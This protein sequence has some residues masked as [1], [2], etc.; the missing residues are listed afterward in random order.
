MDASSGSATSSP[1]ERL[2]GEH[3]ET[4]SALAERARR[5]IPGG[6]HTYA[7]GD[8]QFPVLA[9]PFIARGN[10]CRTWDLDGNQYIE[11]AMG[12][13]AVT[14][15]H[16]YAPV[17]EAARQQ[18][19]FGANFNRPAPIEVEC[20]EAFLSLLP[21]ADMV[22]FTKDGSTALDAAVRLSR[23]HTKRD[24]VAICGDHPFFSTS[25]WFI[26]TTGMP[27]G[28]PEWIRSRTIS[29]SYNDLPSVERM[30]AAYPQQIACV[31]LEAAR[32]VEPA[33]G[34]LQGLQDIC[35]RVGAVLVFDEMITGFRWHRS[36]AQHVYGVTPDLSTFGKALAN[37]FALSAIAGRRE[38]MQL[39]GMDHDKERV[40]LLSTT[41]GAETH[42][43][44][45]AIATM[46]VYREEP[47][48]EHLHRQGRRLRTGIEQ[49]IARHGLQGHFSCVGRD[50]CLLFGTSDRD[51][52]PSQAFR[53]LFMQEMIRRGVL[54]PSFV[55]SYSHGDVDI[56]LTIDAADASLQVYRQALDSGVEKFLVGRPVKP[57]FRRFA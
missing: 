4:G 12:L 56:D 57:V 46:K 35:K 10:G 8:D 51:R 24:Y 9:P 30:F 14:L 53:A 11:Y 19:D 3:F 41:H 43:M 6:A 7:K 32:T 20:A 42:A 18:L 21:G 47:V 17:V 26:G 23:S 37:G 31:V 50:C 22:K 29:F 33:P 15:G 39:G 28:I 36:G 27:G 38:L 52:K 55:V 25:D 5:V 54:A 44:A 2:G 48:T 16:A 1:A 13:R 34:F 40:F 49:S 45:A